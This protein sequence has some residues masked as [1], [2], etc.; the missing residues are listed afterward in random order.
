MSAS[1]LLASR[2]RRLGAWCIDAALVPTL[3][4]V[5]IMI[6]DV[7]EDAE[8][9]ITNWWMLQVL[10]LA[11]F[12]Y[13]LLNGYTLW[14][15]GQTLGKRVFGIRVVLRTRPDTTADFWR[16][17]LAR[18]W[19]FPLPFLLITTPVFPLALVVLAD[20]VPIFL[21]QRMCLHDWLCGTQVV[22]STGRKEGNEGEP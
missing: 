19:F 5:L 3:T 21:R 13:L 4:V 11:I 20:I 14:R 18:A 9:Y 8:D 17:V 10:G 6:T 2:V 15:S 22:H 12:S 1:P 16:L 7:L